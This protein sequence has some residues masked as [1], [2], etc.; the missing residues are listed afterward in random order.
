M[1]Q[2][3]A[4]LNQRVI[5]PV[6]LELM[7][8]KKSN[9]QESANTPLIICG[10]C[11]RNPQ[12]IKCLPTNSAKPRAFRGGFIS[13]KS[14][15]C[16]EVSGEVEWFAIDK[17][18]LPK[19]NQFQKPVTW[20]DRAAIW[21]NPYNSISCK[22]SPKVRTLNRFLRIVSLVKTLLHPPNKRT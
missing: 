15:E 8:G 1:F 17:G 14:S 10:C 18:I 3:N 9:N 13:V 21:A 7:L 11:T 22:H 5:Y 6:W 20:L 16:R 2:S 19:V 4:H 12:P